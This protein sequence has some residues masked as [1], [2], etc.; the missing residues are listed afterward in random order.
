[1]FCWAWNIFTDKT[2]SWHKA[3]DLGNNSGLQNSAVLVFSWWQSTSF[4]FFLLCSFPLR[5]IPFRIITWLHQMTQFVLNLFLLK[6]LSERKIKSCTLCHL[7]PYVFVNTLAFLQKNETHILTEKI[8]IL[9]LSKI[10]TSAKLLSSFLLH[11]VW[12]GCSQ[13]RQFLYQLQAIV[14]HLN[15]VH[16]G[17]CL[18]F[19]SLFSAATTFNFMLSIVLSNC[20]FKLFFQIVLS[21]CSFNI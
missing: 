11:I 1:M 10:K 2:V 14:Q 4:L 18:C 20:S 15:V 17:K 3:R 13:L 12:R 9:L 8:F 5:S 16:V 7:Q 21:N 19:L 6:W